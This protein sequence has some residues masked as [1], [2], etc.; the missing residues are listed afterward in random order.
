MPWLSDGT[1]SLGVS[2]QER[3]SCPQ[4]E[5]GL[6]EEATTGSGT[7]LGISVPHYHMPGDRELLR[8]DTRA[9]AL[10][11]QGGEPHRV[12]EESS[13]HLFTVK[14]RQDSACRRQFVLLCC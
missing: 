13:A 1:E 9:R 4:Q 2:Q 10:G 14:N 6:W 8:G 7:L 3:L 11:R 12:E 5:K